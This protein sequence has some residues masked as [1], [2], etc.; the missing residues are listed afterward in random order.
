MDDLKNTTGPSLLTAREKEFLL[1]FA[2]C[3]MSPV[4]TSKALFFSYNAVYY[5][6]RVIFRKTG[7]NPRNFYD[8]VYLVSCINGEKT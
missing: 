6:C 4:K 7:K 1:M 3:D 2:S 8:L 5:F